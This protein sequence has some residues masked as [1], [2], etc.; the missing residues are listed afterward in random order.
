MKRAASG[1]NGGAIGASTRGVVKNDPRLG[2]AALAGIAA[3]T[4]P[5]DNGDTTL[6]FQII[7]PIDLTG[8]RW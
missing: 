2:A 4:G 7:D 5:E 1:L 3:G 6:V 8:I